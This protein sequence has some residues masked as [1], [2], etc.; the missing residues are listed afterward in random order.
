MRKPD[1]GELQLDRSW[2]SYPKHLGLSAIGDSRTQH[3]K[4]AHHNP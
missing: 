1:Q 3:L 4:K 2:L